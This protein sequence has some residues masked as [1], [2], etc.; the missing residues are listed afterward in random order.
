MEVTV[1]IIAHRVPILNHHWHYTHLLM[2]AAVWLPITGKW[3]KLSTTY[4]QSSD[5]KTQ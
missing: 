3:G 1:R 2:L 4:G 5:G